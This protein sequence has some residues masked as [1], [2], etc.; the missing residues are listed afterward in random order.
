MTQPNRRIGDYDVDSEIAR[1][2]FG[3]IYRA[4]HKDTRH[5]V[6]KLSTRDKLHNAESIANFAFEAKFGRAPQHKT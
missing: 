6:A 1:G 2:G 3:S 5:A 4:F